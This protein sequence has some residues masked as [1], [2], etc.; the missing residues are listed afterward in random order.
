MDV[1]LKIEIDIIYVGLDEILFYL[2]LDNI[3]I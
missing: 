2:G 1:M 3:I